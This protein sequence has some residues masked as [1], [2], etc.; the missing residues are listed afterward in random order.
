[1]VN[2]K[3]LSYAQ[4]RDQTELAMTPKANTTIFMEDYQLYLS[5]FDQDVLLKENLLKMYV[6]YPEKFCWM[7]NKHYTIKPIVNEFS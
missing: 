2:Y 1:M 7:E 4:L 6:K 5:V 3:G